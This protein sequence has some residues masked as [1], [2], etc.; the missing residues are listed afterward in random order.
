MNFKEIIES[1]E[2]EEIEDT[3]IHKFYGIPVMLTAVH[4][5]KQVQK[6]KV[7]LNEPFTKAIALYVSNNTKASYFIKL[8]DTNIDSNS[9]II[10]EYKIKLL[11]YIKSNGIKLVIDLHGANINRDFDIEF[12]TL[13]N[14]SIDF[15]TV[16]ELEESFNKN[17]IFNIKY[18]EPF[19]GGGITQYIYQNT[20]IDV[21]QIE[22]N[23]KYRDIRNSENIEKVCKSLIDFINQYIGSLM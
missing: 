2:Y 14:L 7:K 22:I 23:Q 15:S 19:K 17:G 11:D 6:D 16:K 1:L 18:N 5:M 9:L 3:Y 12:G 13:N 20:D 10:D 21:I 8:K 4:T